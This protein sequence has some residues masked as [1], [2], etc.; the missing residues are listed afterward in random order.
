M[1]TFVSLLEKLSRNH[2]D[3][4]LVGGL[5]V[6]ICGFSRATLDVDIII[7]H[8]SSNIERLLL[9]LNDFGD[10]SASELT[11][12]DFELEEGCIRIV[13]SFPLDVF[14]IMRG[15]IYE[16]L[17]EYKK[18]FRSQNGVKIPYLNQDGLILLKKGSL[19]PKDQID[20][21]ELRKIRDAKQSLEENDK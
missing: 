17:F 1:E 5:A 10:G 7:K 2:I 16:Q 6:D 9:T 21:I 15:N 20:V 11:V 8:N 3:Y 14:T 13:E 4:L 12:K 19:R 18:V